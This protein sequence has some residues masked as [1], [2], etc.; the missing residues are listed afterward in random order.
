MTKDEMLLLCLQRLEDGLETPGHLEAEWSKD[1]RALCEQIRAALASP[2]EPAC[3]HE[4][5]STA[6]NAN[7][8]VTICLDCG[9]RLRVEHKPMPDEDLTAERTDEPTEGAVTVDHGH[10]IETATGVHKTNCPGCHG[11]RATAKTATELA[12]EF[13]PTIQEVPCFFCGVK[14][15]DHAR[16]DHP[17]R[18]GSVVTD[19]DVAVNALR[20]G[21]GQ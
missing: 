12:Q 1:D 5:Q 2:A 14:L 4:T 15:L 18:R 10:I 8:I 16:A 7:V 11:E 9:K 6:D 19:I 20:T 21:D 3:E 13:G 17:W